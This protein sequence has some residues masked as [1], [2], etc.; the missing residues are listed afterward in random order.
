MDFFDYVQVRFS[1]PFH[2][3]MQHLIDLGRFESKSEI[4]RTAINY[5]EDEFEY[6][7]SILED[8]I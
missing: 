3:I 2:Q 4:I 5:F 6:E 7:R 8:N 1:E